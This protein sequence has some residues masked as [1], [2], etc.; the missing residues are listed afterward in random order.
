MEPKSLST[1]Q[2]LSLNCSHCEWIATV[3]SG[4]P[5]ARPR[6][7]I[8]KQDPEV[9]DFIHT[10]W[11]LRRPYRI[12]RRH[13]GYLVGF[14]NGEWGGALLWYAPD[15][16][17]REK[18]LSDRIVEI[19]PNVASSVILTT[20]LGGEGRAI[21]V[22][23]AESKFRVGRSTP[24]EGELFAAA[25]LP[26]EGMVVVTSRGL[27]KLESDLSVTTLFRT[28][29]GQVPN[30]VV[31]DNN[32]TF[33]MGFRGGVM[34]FRKAGDSY[35]EDWLFPVA[36]GDNPSRCYLARAA[37]SRLELAQACSVALPWPK[38]ANSSLEVDAG[39]CSS[40]A[41]ASAAGWT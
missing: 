33:Y 29:L 38:I 1:D 28:D 30:G 34:R 20:G 37:Q 35:R 3:E 5:I 12:V 6:L 17:L 7:P 24:L 10:P 13:P 2:K 40:T 36:L 41:R 11:E 9:P 21:V 4:I 14:N 15:G 31:M 23:E 18:L 27:F 39:L 22:T 8:D 16:T 26:L 32:G 19:L 25:Q